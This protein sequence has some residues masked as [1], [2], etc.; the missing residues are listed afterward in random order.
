MSLVQDITERKNEEEQ[1]AFDQRE[2]EALI[3]TTDDLIWSVSKDYK[4][5][6]G[7]NAFIRRVKELTGF[8]VKPGDN[9]MSKDF[10][11][12]EIL[13]FWDAVYS[14]ALSGRSF[15]YEV[16]N[17][18]QKDSAE[19]WGETSFN[20]IFQ[21]EKVVAFT[22]YSRDIT[23]R[24][25][26]EERIKQSE[27]NMAEAQ[28]LA[29]LG[30]WDYDIRQDKLS[31]SDELYNVFGTN[32][33]IF[34]VTF[35][36]F[37]N[38]VDE[39]DKDNLL[40]TRRHTLTTGEPFTIEYGITTHA[41]EQRIICENGSGQS[42]ENGKIVRL[43]GTAQDI[44]D[45]KK[46]EEELHLM[47]EKLRNLSAHLQNTQEHERTTIAREIHDALGQQL[48]ALK[49]EVGWLNKKLPDEQ[50]LKEKANDILLMIGDI[51]KTV[52]RIAIGLRPGI[53]DDL[54]L[55]AALEW[56]GQEF[57]KNTGITFQ[58][59]CDCPAF[60]PDRYLS[61]HIFRISQEALTNV[62]RHAEASKIEMTL[63]TTN[64]IVKL[65]I[66]DDGQGFDL[67]E[68]KNTDSLGLIGM[69]ERALMLMGTFQIESEKSKG[70]EITL[71]IPLPDAN[72]IES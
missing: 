35:D 42:D 46:A 56:Q 1:K 32:K 20:P 63:E 12:E 52:K 36:S 15:R 69:N 13:L 2:K 59:H 34:K 45:R 29:N 57:E 40:Q 8:T 33:T 17:A 16:F 71:T 10:F 47:N 37:L 38:L 11:S 25:Q 5:I 68:I 64:E 58:F 26:S 60:N 7:N 48:T 61:T 65:T 30:N 50:H 19:N 43:F 67:E 24:K 39:K 44:T 22:C 21:D 72:K 6:A 9:L 28:R 3:N 54:G 27:A 55:I 18:A 62:A 31:W 49:M 51:L 4:L 53:L 23:E 66:Q 70:T 14:K 41:G